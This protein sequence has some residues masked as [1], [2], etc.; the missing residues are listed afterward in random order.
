[1]VI[2]TEDGERVIHDDLI[3]CMDRPQTVG[4]HLV[5]TLYLLTGERII[6]VVEPREP[7]EF[8]SLSIH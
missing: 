6:G 7:E 1:M 5:V 2:M 3:L 4:N 8:E